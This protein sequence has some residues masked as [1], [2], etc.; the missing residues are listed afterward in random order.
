[1]VV[2][3][4]GVRTYMPDQVEGRS[5]GEMILKEESYN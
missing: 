2:D 1:M 5:V 4:L 3:I